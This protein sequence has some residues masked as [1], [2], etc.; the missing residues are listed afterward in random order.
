M[1]ERMF[2]YYRGNPL[3]TGTAQKN[4]AMRIVTEFLKRT[5]KAKVYEG[6]RMTVVVIP[7]VMGD[8]MWMKNNIMREGDIVGISERMSDIEAK[9][10]GMVAKYDE[11]RD[12]KKY[13]GVGM[14]KYWL[15]HFYLQYD[16]WGPDDA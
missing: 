5:C 10:D 7:D 8:A 11:K 15:D 9:V 4:N 16:E 12:G 2:A 14:L 1:K 3:I 13:A 6:Q